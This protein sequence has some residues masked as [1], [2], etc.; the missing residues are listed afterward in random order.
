MKR[1]AFLLCGLAACLL[2]QEAE[3]GF[4]MRTT[5]SSQA[6][7]S[8]R[9][10]ASPRY[11]SPLTAGFRGM[12]YPVYKI[13]R[14]WTVS[15]TVQLHTRPYFVEQ[16]ST[17][18]YGAKADVLQALVTYSRFS[19][20]R[21]IVVRAGQLSSSFGSFL[22]RYDDADNALIDMPLMYGYYYQPVTTYGLPGAQVDVTLGKVDA[23]VQFA[24]SSPVNRRSVFDKDQYPNWA[25]G[26]GYTIAPGFR[27]G[28]SAYRGPYLHREH[29]HFSPGEANPRELP[30]TGYGLDVQWGRGPWNVYGELQRFKKDY[31]AVP[32][33]HQDGGYAEVRRVLHPRW[34]LAGRVAYLRSS[35]KSGTCS[36]YETAVGYRPNRYQLVKVG[37]QKVDSVTSR[38]NLADSVM[39]QL[40][41]SFRALSI[42]R[43]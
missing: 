13:N 2:A 21:S 42:A 20:N 14:N 16:F 11:G 7:Y 26:A 19:N 24:T 1:I 4:A 27:V 17:Q 28:A 34:Y 30:A 36:V 31:R 33:V 10:S 3:S 12:L 40:V 9:L 43:D 8:H 35:T 6:M 23:R 25:G 18:G 5:I 22:L 15:S 29:K 39:I 32:V 41:T 38:G 37:Y